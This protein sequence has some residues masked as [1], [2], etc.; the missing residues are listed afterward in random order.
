MKGLIL[1]VLC[2]HL[3]TTFFNIMLLITYKKGE[4]MQKCKKKQQTQKV[5]YALMI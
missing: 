4:Q 2:N 5:N 1:D 3:Y